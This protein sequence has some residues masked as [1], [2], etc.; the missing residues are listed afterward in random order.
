MPRMMRLGNQ[1]AKTMI[2]AMT[3]QRIRTSGASI[4]VRMT[5]HEGAMLRRFRSVPI[6]RA[7]WPDGIGEAAAQTLRRTA[8]AR[9]M[10]VG[11]PGGLISRLANGPTCV[12]MFMVE[13]SLGSNGRPHS[14]QR[15]VT[16]PWRE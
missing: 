3:A 10:N 14:G 9:S 7:N 11:Q 5:D 8:I 13:G 16:R 4:L 2:Q 1:S 6:M 15:G 12:S